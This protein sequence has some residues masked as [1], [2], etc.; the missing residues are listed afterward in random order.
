MIPSV[1]SEMS[2]D[3]C[4]YGRSSGVGIDIKEVHCVELDPPRLGI[5]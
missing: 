1:A 3:G 2:R 5:W 4:K